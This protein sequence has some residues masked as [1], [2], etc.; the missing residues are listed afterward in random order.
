MTQ[1]DK[2]LITREFPEYPLDTIPQDI[3]GWLECGA[4]HNDSCPV[5]GDESYLSG[6]GGIALAIDYADHAMRDYG[7]E[8][9]EI[10]SPRF[11]CWRTEWT[12]GRG[13]E[14]VGDT[15]SSD[16]WAAVLARLEELRA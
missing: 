16:D 15:F 6:N 14:Q 5:W 8:A 12:S 3:P 10:P 4:W 11:S 13:T 1:D 7:G 2:N 9:P